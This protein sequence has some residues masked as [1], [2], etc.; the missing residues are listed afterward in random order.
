MFRLDIKYWNCHIFVM[1][2]ICNYLLYKESLH[3]IALISAFEICRKI[4]LFELFCDKTFDP[5]LTLMRN[6]GKCFLTMNYTIL[7][8]L[9]LV[10][11]TNQPKNYSHVMR[12]CYFKKSC[13]H[14]VSDENVD[15]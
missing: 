2:I 15:L 3:K 11:K 12:N 6:H 14:P 8:S 4:Y 7:I 10:L 1:H 13:F 5:F 9:A